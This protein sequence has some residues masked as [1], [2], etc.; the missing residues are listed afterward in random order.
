MVEPITYGNLSRIL[1][2]LGFAKHDIPGSHVGYEHSGSGTIILLAAHTSKQMA[3]M[4]DV[5]YVRRV[6]DEKGLL[7]GKEFDRRITDTYSSQTA[8]G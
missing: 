1:M 6:L 4:I 2:D 3:R 7:D 8:K 5:K